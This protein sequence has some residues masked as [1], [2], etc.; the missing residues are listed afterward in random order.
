MEND[1]SQEGSSISNI[2][3]IRLNHL[4]QRQPPVRYRHSAD[5]PSLLINDTTRPV[6]EV[7]QRTPK[8]EP[9]MPHFV[10]RH[11]ISNFENSCY[12]DEKVERFFENDL[13]FDQEPTEPSS[14]QQLNSLLH[15]E[16]VEK[17][18][19]KVLEELRTFYS[20]TCTKLNSKTIIVQRDI[21]RFWWVL[22]RQ[23]ID[24]REHN[25]LF[26]PEKQQQMQ[27]VRITNF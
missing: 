14:P 19:S 26:L 6:T 12:G 7:L 11:D 27:E 20:D 10:E 22:Q 2:M 18:Q 17:S 15:T 25:T 21:E 13:S 24:F 3:E 5:S 16:E 8:P 23:K 1:S 4:R 9:L